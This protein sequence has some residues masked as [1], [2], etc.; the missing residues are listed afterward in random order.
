MSLL[1]TRSPEGR[2]GTHAPLIVPRRR[3]PWCPSGRV[4][5][6]PLGY[7]T[8]RAGTRFPLAPE[9]MNPRGNDIPACTTCISPAHPRHKILAGTSTDF[10]SVLGTQ[11][12]PH[13]CYMTPTH[14]MRIPRSR[15]PRVVLSPLGRQIQ[16]GMMSIFRHLRARISLQHMGLQPKGSHP[17]RR[18]GTHV[19]VDMVSSAPRRRRHRCQACSAAQQHLRHPLSSDI[20]SRLGMECTLLTLS[21]KTSLARTAY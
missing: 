21:R 2:L 14:G 20:H 6:R 15:T 11:S 7:S 10:H 8:C 5:P 1:G 16:H 19:L 12:P 17:I 13:K 18:L 3:F 4:G 9:R